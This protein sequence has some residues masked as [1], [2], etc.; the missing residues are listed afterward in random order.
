MTIVNYRET[1][2]PARI[3]SGRNLKQ[4]RVHLMTI[5][6]KK[7]DE[8]S[9][10]MK[11]FRVKINV[12]ELL[13]FNFLFIHLTNIISNQCYCN[14]NNNHTLIVRSVEKYNPMPSISKCHT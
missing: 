4:K 13:N 9:V 8:I 10:H 14:T 5:H 6:K 7:N 11:I 1:E 3:R 2:A 12:R